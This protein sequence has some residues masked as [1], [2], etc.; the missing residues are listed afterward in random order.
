M[1]SNIQNKLTTEYKNETS[2]IYES[3][4][5]KLLKYDHKNQLAS[6]IC[7][8]KGEKIIYC[9]GESHTLSSHIIHY[10]FT[11]LEEIYYCKSQLIM[12]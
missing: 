4:L 3:L 8:N 9:I 2:V 1:S 6:G 10:S 11:S 5:T 7:T 12:G